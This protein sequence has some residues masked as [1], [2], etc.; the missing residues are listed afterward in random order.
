MG[1]FF[2]S[3]RRADYLQLLRSVRNAVARKILIF[4][5]LWGYLKDE[6]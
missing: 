4:R 1:N 2:T 6:T 5:P 3:T